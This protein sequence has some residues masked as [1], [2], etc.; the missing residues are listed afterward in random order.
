MDVY[1][2]N[3][4][5]GRLIAERAVQ[6]GHRPILAGRHPQRVIEAAR[7]LDLPSAVFDLGDAAQAARHLQQAAAVIH[8]AGPFSATAKPMLDTCLA[9]G[10]HYLDITGEIS[11]FEMIHGRSAELRAGG[12]AAIPGVGFDVVPTDC[13]AALLKER[14]P[15][16]DQLKLAFTTLGGRPS[17]GT[18]KTMVEGLKDGGR[19]RRDGVIVAVP[20]VY[21]TCTVP[22]PSAPATAM[23]IGWGDVATAFYSTGI[24]NIE[25]YMAANA[26][27]IAL[28]RVYGRTR[29]LMALP[30]VVRYLKRRVERHVVGPNAERRARSTT[31]LWG[32]V[33]NRRGDMVSLTMRAPDGYSLTA[34]A[35][36]R[37]VEHLLAAA[38][39]PG[40]LTPSLAFG[41]GFVKE[42]EGVELLA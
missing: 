17:P 26:K 20:A 31:E 15:D 5:T 25:V 3:G 14:L 36:V 27:T 38:P 33:R 40:A 2:A 34:D 21:K 37:A 24:P 19:I 30:P 29:W 28:A 32:E 9:A 6:R 7:A 16:A 1:G 11:V 13:L 8:C 12:I 23:S 10:T 41:A 18:A 42:L 35:A 22:F 4:Y 39:P